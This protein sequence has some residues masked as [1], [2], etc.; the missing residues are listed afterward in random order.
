MAGRRRPDYRRVKIHRSYTVDEAARTLGVHKQTVRAW[1]ANGLPTIDERRPIM[2]QGQALFN[3][4][5]DARRK[6]KRPCAMDE[7]YCVKCR[8]PKVPAGRMVDYLPQTDKY[9]NLLGICPGCDTMIPKRVSRAKLDAIGGVLDITFPQ[10]E[11]DLREKN[12]PSLNH[13][14]SGREWTDETQRQE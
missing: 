7:I 12:S 6:A 9:G 5:H 13:D 14:S 10:A 8:A 11:P 2:I 3:F 4:L 1:I